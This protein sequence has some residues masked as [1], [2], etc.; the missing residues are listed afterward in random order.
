MVGAVMGPKY[1]GEY[2]R[3][4]TKELLGDLTLKQTLTTVIIPTFDIKHLQPVLFSTIDVRQQQSI[5]R[6]F[7]Q[8]FGIAVATC[9]GI[10]I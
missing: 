1:D 2:L 10:L 7:T 9:V 8:F 5:S 6:N 3:T 4:L